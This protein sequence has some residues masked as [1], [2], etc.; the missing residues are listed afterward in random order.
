M[1]E[2]MKREVGWTLPEHPNIMMRFDCVIEESLLSQTYKQATGCTVH[3]IIANNLIYAG[4]RT[5]DQLERA[6]QYYDKNMSHQMQQVVDRLQLD[7]KTADRLVAKI[8]STT[9]RRRLQ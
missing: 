5:R 3:A 8:D 2:T 1:V 4:T 9:E 6:V 7:K